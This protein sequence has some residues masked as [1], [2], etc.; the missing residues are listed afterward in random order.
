VELVE[1]NVGSSELDADEINYGAMPDEQ[2]S[3]EAPTEVSP[4]LKI[5]SRTRREQEI[6]AR[7]RIFCWR[8]HG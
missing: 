8:R 5:G 3:T 1:N 4:P 7:R 6:S 2:A